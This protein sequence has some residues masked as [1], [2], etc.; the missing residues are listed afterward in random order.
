MTTSESAL[1]LLQADGKPK[2]V[3]QAPPRLV[4]PFAASNGSRHPVGKPQPPEEEVVSQTGATMNLQSK[5][6]MAAAAYIRCMCC[7]L[8][9][10]ER[11]R[12]E[13]VHPQPGPS[14]SATKNL[15]C[16]PLVYV[17]K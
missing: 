4:G 2:R 16:F 3:E 9:T 13:G 7:R 11:N 17:N 8:E 12:R 1:T 10:K 5:Q 14:K 15:Q 6:E